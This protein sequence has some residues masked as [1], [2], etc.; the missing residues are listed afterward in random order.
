M[1]GNKVL[2]IL[3]IIFFTNINIAS[4]AI[5]ETHSTSRYPD[6][7]YEFTGK[8]RCE[9]FNR[10]LFIFNLKL[11][12]Y[13]LRPVN[14]VWASIM[15]KYGMDRIKNVYTNINFPTRLVSCALQKDYKSL[16]HEAKRFAIN[17]TMGVGGLYDVAQTK[18]KMEPRQEDMQQA[19]AHY[20]KIKP[21]PYLFLPVIHGNLRDDVGQILNYPLNPCAYVLGPF[22]IVA[23]AAFYINNSTYLQPLIKKVEL[24]YADPYELIRQADGVGN[25]IKSTNLDRKDVFA[26]K[27]ST[28]NI[29]PINNVADCP[30]LKPDIRLSDYNPQSPLVDAMRTSLFDNMNPNNS[31]WADISLWNKSFDKKLKTASVKLYDKRDKYK[32]K[33]ILQKDKN[34]P[35]AIIFPSI[36]E[37]IL[38]DKSLVQTKQLYDEGYSV[39]ILGST[40]NWEFVK[41]MPS[42]YRP[43]LPDNDAKY[44][45]AATAKV[46]NDIQSKHGYNFNNKIVVGTSFGA[47]TGLFVAAQEHDE[48][49]LNV[50]HYIAINPPVETFFAINQADKYSQEWKNSP[51]DIKARAAITVEKVLQKTQEAS[52]KNSKNKPTYFPFTDDEAKLILGFFMKQK[53]YDL[54][55]TIENGSRAKKNKLYESMNN[56]SFNDYAQKYLLTNP[57]KSVSQV[58][59]EAS[60]YSIANFLQTGNN[61]KIYHSID[62]YYANPQQLAWLKKQAGERVVYFSNGSHLG[63]LYRPEFIAEFKKEIKFK[64]ETEPAI[65]RE[66]PPSEQLQDELAVQP[67]QPRLRPMVQ[68]IEQTIEQPILLPTLQPVSE[69]KSGK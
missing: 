39:I 62:D 64:I 68:P 61:Y 1:T 66:V 21:G 49:T 31:I 8:D 15:P 50:S 44:L 18:F 11:N 28:E 5:E 46:L 32:Y 30:D 2:L 25:Y 23:T 27:T 9:S 40:C 41:S 14:I 52:D 58:D 37:G 29:V 19:L 59:Y 36:G 55:F 20:K 6:Y 48:N 56:L 67:E 13:I 45:R 7:A 12:K 54:V 57:E 53:L 3:A 38:S 42:S 22:S 65:V 24:T 63:E 33:Y 10:K 60:L 51:E 4:F 35:V 34:A 26:E 17:T 16:K 43:G 47:I 69:V